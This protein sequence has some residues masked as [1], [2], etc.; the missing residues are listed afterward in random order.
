MSLA[1]HTDDQVRALAAAGDAAA[2]RE[3]VRRGLR[4]DPELARA[5]AAV[6][7]YYRR[8]LEHAA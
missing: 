3:L 4:A 8:L 6:A 5:A 2:E 7:A 1:A